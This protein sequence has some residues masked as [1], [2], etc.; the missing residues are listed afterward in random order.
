MA[1]L[2]TLRRRIAGE[3]VRDLR[4]R[5]LLIEESHRRRPRYFDGRFLAARDLTRDQAYFL[6]RQAA[7][8]RA[9]G[10]GVVE[11]LEVSVGTS[12]DRIRVTR[13]F[14]YT[15]A[16]EL[17]SL[18]STLEV[19]LANLPALQLLAARLQLDRRRLPPLRNRAGVFVLGLRPLE[20]TANPV[21]AYPSGLEAERQVENGDVVEA[22]ALTLAPLAE[23]APRTIDALRARMAKR[24]FV[25]Q[26]PLDVP[27]ELLPLAVIALAGDNARWIDTALVRTAAGQPHADVLGFGFAPRQLREMHL[28]QYRA[29][30]EPLRDRRFAA[31]QFFDALPPAGPLPRGAIDANDFSQTF[32][33]AGVDAELSIVPEDEVAA[34]VEE[35]MTLPPIDLEASAQALDATFVSILLPLPR[36]QVRVF[37]QRL[38]GGLVRAPRPRLPFSLVRRLPVETLRLIDRPIFVRPAPIDPNAPIDNAWREALALALRSALGIWYSRRRSLAYEEAIAGRTVSVRAAIEGSRLVDL[39][40]GRL[41]ELGLADRF[42]TLSA[43]TD[44]FANA[45]MTRMLA[46]PT[47]ES[48]VLASAALSALESRERLDAAAVEEVAADFS[49]PGTGEGLNRLAALEPDLLTRPE[50]VNRLAASDRLLELDRRLATENPVAAR[51]LAANVREV[52]TT[53]RTRGRG[54]MTL[55]RLLDAPR[56][57]DTPK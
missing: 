34:L 42:R 41:G 28:A 11:G 40:N 51:E 9:V 32:F 45:S 47:F 26:V 24:V 38:S 1:D 19:S 39:V 13:G 31:T 36:E 49:R 22:A 7:Y 33:P 17:V 21:A 16:G 50:A 54:A 5:N 23:A 4:E 12:P 6:A 57:L 44:V 29:Q 48:P 20:F 35:A 46:S 52:I 18:Q 53:R 15:S 8:A 56:P 2:D 30:L 37:A 10:P 25:E 3:L 27:A 55:D 43:R 14:G